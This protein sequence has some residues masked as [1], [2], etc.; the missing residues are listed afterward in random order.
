MSIVQNPDG[1][2]AYLEKYNPYKTEA[3]QTEPEGSVHVM[4][5][6]QNVYIPAETYL[7]A[8]ALQSY[9]RFIKLICLV[10]G[11]VSAINIGIQYPYGMIICIISICGYQ[12]A[13]QYNKT[14]LQIYSG[15]QCTKIIV[16]CVLL[17]QYT[18]SYISVF[19]LLSTLL[20]I[21]IIS[22]CKKF[23]DLLP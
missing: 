5:D 9:A 7:V 12:G 8:E 23:I 21:Y 22:I 15:Y 14:Y 18:I 11:F 20:D 3:T 17:I 1:Q 2:I 19:T 4:I 13:V 16:K 6:N 10:D